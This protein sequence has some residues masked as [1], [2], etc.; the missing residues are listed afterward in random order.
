MH[1]LNTE[2]QRLGP[3]LEKTDAIIITINLNDYCEI[4][5]AQKYLY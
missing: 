4:V 1:A 5:L 2:G 3:S